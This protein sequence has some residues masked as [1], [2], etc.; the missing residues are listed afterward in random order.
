M[1]AMWKETLCDCQRIIWIMMPPENFRQ[2]YY[3][4]RMQNKLTECNL[5]FP[6][7]KFDDP[8]ALTAVHYPFLLLPSSAQSLRH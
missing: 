8:Q 1:G 3:T 2:F 7:P 5:E 6:A 4:E